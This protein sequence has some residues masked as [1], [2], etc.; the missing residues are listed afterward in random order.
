M[1]KTSSIVEFARHGDFIVVSADLAELVAG[2]ESAVASADGNSIARADTACT[3][4]PCTTVNGVCPKQ[5]ICV[6]VV[7]I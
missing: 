6:Q 7:C 5:S 1:K 4:V 2:G 3:N